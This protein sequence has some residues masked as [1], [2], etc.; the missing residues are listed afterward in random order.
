M[1]SSYTY[2]VRAHSC[3]SFQE[4]S[5]IIALLRV[6]H[7]QNRPGTSACTVSHRCRVSR[8]HCAGSDQ[9]SLRLLHSAVHSL[10]AAEHKS[11]VFCIISGIMMHSLTWGLCL[12]VMRHRLVYFRYSASSAPL[13]EHFSCYTVPCISATILGAVISITCVLEHSRHRGTCRTAQIF[14]CLHLRDIEHRA[15][16]WVIA[17]LES[18]AKTVLRSRIVAS[19]RQNVACRLVTRP[20]PA[21]GRCACYRACIPFCVNQ[22][23]PAGCSI[24]L[25]A[26]YAAQITQTNT[27]GGTSILSH[28]SRRCCTI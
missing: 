21:C 14:Y 10:R 17:V 24:I 11:A 28:V 16:P 23:P 15:V 12:S 4:H 19:V 26:T 18:G 8:F 6:P 27:M 13:Q 2:F 22:T 5:T 25:A 9:D 3:A 20:R 1:R 7:R